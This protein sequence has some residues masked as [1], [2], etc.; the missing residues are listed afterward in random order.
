M[1]AEKYD[2]QDV[3]DAVMLAESEPSHEALLRWIKRY[4][5]F[6]KELENYFVAWSD[7]EMR[8][9]LPDPVEIDEN[10]IIERAVKRTIAKLRNQERTRG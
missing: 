5:R 9:H 2:L 7:A 3:L 6:S 10:S 1:M 8:T 4:P